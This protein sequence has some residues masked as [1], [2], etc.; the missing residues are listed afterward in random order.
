[1]PV[2]VGVIQLRPCKLCVEKRCS[3]A[4][5]AREL[6]PAA[7]HRALPTHRFFLELLTQRLSAPDCSAL[8]WLLDGFPHT[9]AQ[10]ARLA[11]AGLVPDKAIFLEG[12]HLLLMERV[13]CASSQRG[14]AW[15]P[16]TLALLPSVR[17]C[18]CRPLLHAAASWETF[19]WPLLRIM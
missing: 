9:K 10:A 15:C 16:D 7:P 8:G 1:V 11:A 19:C 13:R 6:A 17:A 2:F 14:A 3:R 5:W 18:T 12:Q 4:A